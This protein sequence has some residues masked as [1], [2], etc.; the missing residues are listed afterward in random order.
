MFLKHVGSFR[1]T[2]E[3][4]LNSE[5]CKV[6]NLKVLEGDIE[7]TTVTGQHTIRKTNLDV[8]EIWVTRD[9]ESE[10]V[11]T[12]V[13]KFF[14]NMERMDI[15]GSKIKQISREV[16]KGCRKVTKVCVL[17]TTLTTFPEDTFSDL[18][19]LK[20]LFIYENKLVAL[21]EKLVA[22][23]ANL[24][25]LSARNNRLAMIDIV[26][27]LSLKSIDLR[28]NTCIDKRFPEDVN[29]LRLF[30]KQVGDDCESPLKKLMG[31][32]IATF[33]SNLTGLVNEIKSLK[34]DNAALEK[35]KTWLSTNVTNLM[36]ELTTL[37]GQNSQRVLEIQAIK[38]NNTK[39]IDLVYNEN[40]SL[41]VNLTMCQQLVRMKVS[42]NTRIRLDNDN[43]QSKFRTSQ[44]QIAIINASH[45]D[46]VASYKKLQEKF[47]IFEMRSQNINESLEECWEN[48]TITFGL[49]SELTMK[50]TELEDRP[51][52][53][54]E[55]CPKQ[56]QADTL[57]GSKCTG[58]GAGSENIKA[59]YFITLVFVFAGIVFA[60]VLYMRRKAT[61][62]LIAQMIT[63]RVSMRHL[64]PDE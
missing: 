6:I 13:C 27:D 25:S 54:H 45:V 2:C 62:M 44:Q 52:T 3:F 29:S 30:N 4:R 22:N 28:A 32:K 33:Q 51:P 46:N 64:I 1:L 38:T 14:E 12:N 37:K 35:E 16:F 11:P 7:V 63:Q 26:F 55:I 20:E 31:E 21:P 24:M 36:N 48:L 18:V 47:E 34:M 58:L 10:I 40:I 15:Y 57:E 9:V 56:P 41:K 53:V 60:T 17:F 8:K 42:E 5:E 23:N 59:S 43:V 61:R 50:I 39:Q 49:N 19:A